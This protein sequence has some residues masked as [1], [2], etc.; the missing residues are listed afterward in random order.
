M[1]K[2]NKS[3]S[4]TMKLKS[5]NK[6]YKMS[7]EEL[8]FMK[9]NLSKYNDNLITKSESDGELSNPDSEP[10]EPTESFLNEKLNKMIKEQSFNLTEKYDIVE[11]AK[12]LNSD[13]IDLEWK[14]RIK[15]YRK[16]SHFGSI[17]VNYKRN[18]IGRL[19]IKCEAFKDKDETLT[20]QSF[21][22][23]V[24]KSALCSKIYND[25]DLVNCHP[26]ML[27][28]LLISYD[29]DCPKIH[30]Y[31]LLRDD[32]IKYYQARTDMNRDD[33]KQLLCLI[34]YGGSA[35]KFLNE[36][37]VPDNEEC[38]GYFIELENELKSC[39]TQLLNKPEYFKYKMKACNDKG[40]DYHNV[41]GT[42]LSY[43]LQTHECNILMVMFNYIKNN[44][45]DD[46]VGALIH[47]GLHINKEKL[48]DYGEDKLIDKLQKAITHQ[49]GFRLKLK[50]KP[51][52]PVKELNNIICVD[53]DKEAGDYVSDKIK[54][55]YITCQERIFLRINNVWTENDKK[56]KKELNKIVGNFNIKMKKLNEK[57]GE[58]E[59]K[60]HSKMCKGCKDILNFVE[61]TEDEDFIDNLWT[62]NLYK[63]CF[64]NGYYDFKSGHLKEYDVD[65]HTTIKINRDFNKAKPEIKE[66]V[67][68]RILDPIFNNDVEMRDCWLNYIAR[69]LAGH[70]ED[71]N[72]AVGT[73]ERDCGK[74][75]LVGLLENCFGE[76]CRSTNSE[77]FLFKNNG[78]DSAKALSWL[79]PFEFKRLLLTNE[80]TKDAEDK[81]RING[82][83]LKKLSSGGDKIEARVNHKDEINFKVQARVCMMCNDL[84][85]IEPSDAKE[86]SYMF[87][88]PSKFL[89]EEDPRLENPVKIKVQKMNE[90]TEELE[91]VLD[92]NG[93]VVYKTL[94]QFYK[95]DDEIKN[96]CKKSE[97]MDAF[98]EI[99]FDNYSKKVPIPE[100]MKE[101]QNDFKLEETDE[102]RFYDLFTFMD[103]A[104]YQTDN[105]LDWLSISVIGMMLKKEKINL[106]AQKYKNLLLAKGCVKC[107]K[108]K[109]DGKRVNA[110]A[111]IQVY[112]GKKEELANAGYQLVDESEDE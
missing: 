17:K 9:K 42:A 29:I 26:E 88:Y 24:C 79:V 100:S 35:T 32:I 53:T 38:R 62:S 103:D 3:K 90:E 51:F 18:E 108:T 92:D 44:L 43:L 102:S 57:S 67:F 82:N 52:E 49:T 95:K 30:Q 47:D 59:L 85:P 39:R 89:D 68:R 11:M 83:I 71:K 99:L 48:E 19:E 106:S 101:E 109:K 93:E 84:P 70:I 23:G 56:I 50:I 54:N 96:W 72:W 28:Q 78:Q 77:N 64:K 31:V 81:V 60:E 7:D 94:T 33:I 61:P 76:Y 110:W 10:N 34:C 13:V 55:D 80:I 12:L 37:Q 2:V 25:L 63:L 111:N 41:D 5:D 20:T 22:K 104:N 73:G 98:I 58:I 6:E 4:E 97:V 69:G 46:S 87:K 8:E 91:D 66:Q 14:T 74:G 21:M 40:S 86:T 36:K 105:D 45:G 75:V 1:K 65:T 107:K 27:Y 15:K 16:H 112:K